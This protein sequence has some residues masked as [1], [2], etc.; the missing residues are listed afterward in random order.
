ML[1]KPAPHAEPFWKAFSLA[2]PPGVRAR[3]KEE[4][5]MKSLHVLVLVL[6]GLVL[7]SP[8]AV[9]ASPITFSLKGG[10]DYATMHIPQTSYP[11]DYM[12]GYGGGMT[13]GTPIREHIGI[14]IDILYMRKGA[15][16][17]YP[18]DADPSSEMITN[19]IFL[20]YVVFSPTVRFSPGRSGAGFYVVAGPEIGYLIKASNKITKG[21]N[22]ELLAEGEIDD[23]YDKVDYGASAGMGFTT[24]VSGGPGI[25]FEGRYSLG[26]RNLIHE[27]DFA[28][29]PPVPVT[30]TRAFY[31]MAGITF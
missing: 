27:E 21:P 8:A 9:L 3:R 17:E 1:E 7:A 10:V 15:M 2:R 11:P 31:L 25:F 28:D 23:S 5:Q 12:L 24:A 4:F 26:F 19:K 20:D 16:Q 14:D 13:L 30:K 18:Y 29:Y 6:V 22:D